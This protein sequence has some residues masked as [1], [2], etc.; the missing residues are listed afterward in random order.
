MI[1]KCGFTVLEDECEGVI[2][3]IYIYPNNEAELRGRHLD[4]LTK[5]NLDQASGRVFSNRANLVVMEGRVV[6]TWVIHGEKYVLKQYFATLVDGASTP[7]TVG[8]IDSVAPHT[9]RAFFAHDHIYAMFPKVDRKTAD[10]IYTCFLEADGCNRAARMVQY[11]SLRLF[12]GKAKNY[13]PKAH[14]NWGRVTLKVVP[15]EG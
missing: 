1:K 7:I 13:S 3:P 10:Q 14:W 2:D 4:L 5:A 9:I 8:D 11:A 15:Y 12:G 6:L